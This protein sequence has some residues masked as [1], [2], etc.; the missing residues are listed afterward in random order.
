M[1]DRLTKS[2]ADLLKI[3]KSAIA[4]VKPRDAI[5]KQV[6][7]QS[8]LLS[9]G[10][11]E[12]D[13]SA[14]KRIF[15]IGAGKAAAG[16][17]AG[18]EKILRGM[19]YDGVIATGKGMRAILRHIESME[20]AHPIPDLSS[21]KAAEA[22]LEMAGSLNA[23]DL[24]I[25]LLSGGASAMWTKPAGFL[26]LDDKIRTTRSLINCGADIAEINM[27]RKHLSTIK[28]GWLARA[29]SPARTITLAI[30]DVIGDDPSI[31]G[32]GPT[33]P[34]RTT[35][36]DALSVIEK[37]DL[38]AEIPD[39]VLKH[40]NSGLKGEIAETPKP[41]D[42]D[43]PSNDFF[44]VASNQLALDA[45]EKAARKLGYNTHICPVAV[46]GEARDAGGALAL[47][48]A[49]VLERKEPLP[50]PAV[51]ICGGET[52]VTLRGKGK[53]GRNQELGLAAA[54]EIAGQNGI[55]LASI[56]TD[57]IDGPT[58]AAGAIVDGTTIE[59]GR[60]LGLS[61]S[62]HLL[63]NDSYTYFQ[64]LGDLIQTGPT[65]TNVMD[66]QIAIIGDQKKEDR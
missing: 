22:A 18:L 52:T 24:A 59:R 38:A 10:E 46:S 36:R 16:M 43:L 6:L 7:L 12:I 63:E 45:A 62:D 65:G 15:V 19:I 3:A 42:P 57:G 66:L 9:I 1:N 32:S 13:L 23:D 48:A 35:Y 25:C 47:M 5:L 37:Y 30:S 41:G 53:G 28:G 26:S 34:D 49:Q 14:Y 27:V 54:I 21:L 58:D 4:S 29:I 64:K 20:A 31:I 51:I 50:P 2:R 11:K 8:N 56:G 44:I 60:R 39:P 40:L 61:A 17:G 55:T 33:V